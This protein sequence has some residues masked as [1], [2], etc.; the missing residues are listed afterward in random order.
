MD[1]HKLRRRF[2][3]H[4]LQYVAD[5]NALPDHVELAPM[6]D[7]VHIHFHIDLRQRLHLLPRKHDWLFHFSKD[8][9]LPVLRLDG[10]RG[11]IRQHRP[12]LRQMLP[13]RDAF[14]HLGWQLVAFG[15]KFQ[16]HD[17]MPVV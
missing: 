5:V 4:P 13:R 10:G 9:Q 1:D 11:S 14:L 15:K 17:W 7:A 2:N 6:R 16:G 3:L 12:L 8:A